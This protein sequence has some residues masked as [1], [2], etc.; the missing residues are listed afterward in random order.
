MTQTVPSHTHAR[1]RL[2]WALH[3]AN[4]N[5]QLANASACVYASIEAPD[6]APSLQVS[7]YVPDMHLSA[8]SCP[9]VG[10]QVR[11]LAAWFLR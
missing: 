3:A 4:N 1:W 8:G 5:L 7:P 11:S 2:P 10:T 9:Q 6:L